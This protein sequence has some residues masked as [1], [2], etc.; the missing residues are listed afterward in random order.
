MQEIKRPE[1]AFRLFIRF[2][3]ARILVTYGMD[4]VVAIFK[5]VQGIVTTIMA[6]SS[7]QATAMELPS[8]IVDAINN[9]HLYQYILNL[10]F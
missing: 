10:S 8:T 1:Q 3:V 6:K 2:A 5:I 4:F 9:C 7:F